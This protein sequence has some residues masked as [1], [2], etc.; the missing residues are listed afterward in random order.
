MNVFLGFIVGFFI[1]VIASLFVF[2]L[3]VATDKREKIY[4]ENEEGGGK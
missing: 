4:N 3:C 2:S 1:G